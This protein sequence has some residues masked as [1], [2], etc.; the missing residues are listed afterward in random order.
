MIGAGG[1]VTIPVDVSG[2]VDGTLT[3][4]VFVTSVA[5]NPSAGVTLTATK[6]ATPPALTVTTP[7]AIN[8]SNVGGFSIAVTGEANAG[9]SYSFTDGTHTVSASS[10]IGKK[11]TYSANPSLAAL[12]DGT[13]TLTITETDSSGNQTVYT[14]TL[15]KDTVAPVAPTVALS[16]ASDSGTSNSDYLTNVT[17]PV[18]AVT[19]APGTTVTVYVN[20]VA[21]TGQTLATG[22]YT[23]TAIATDIAGNV[24]PTATAPHQVVIDTTPP[25]GSLTIGG[26]TTIN[27]QAAT[28]APVL[29]LSLS[30]TDAHGPLAMAFSIDGGVTFSLPVAY[31]SSATVTLPSVDGLYTVQVRVTDNA[32]NSA[33]VSKIV[34]LDTTGPAI[35]SSVTAGT[36]GDGSYDLTATAPTL[37]FGA[38]DVDN[39][40]TISATIDSTTAISSG[41][42]INLFALTAGTHTITITAVDQLGNSSIKTVTFQLHA[43]LAGLTFAVTSVNNKVIPAAAHTTLLATL[44]SAQTALS[45]GDATSEKSLLATFVTQVTTPSLNINASYQTLLVSWAND[46]ISRS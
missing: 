43:T 22:T 40:Q 28:K 13:V 36:N 14:A 29:S 20:G 34:R 23:V 15:V 42:A 31:A 18:F 24:S 25:S 16:A 21:Y 7:P 44:A 39:V 5:G 8:L 41:G 26:T 46:L 32:G 17:A 38:T 9:I 3:I 45:H 19:S 6:D 2:L 11:G 37:T 35:T 10:T 30:F 1:S 4:S 12:S 33:T 27:G